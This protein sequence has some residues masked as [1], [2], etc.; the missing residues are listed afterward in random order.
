MTR[1]AGTR[2]GAVPEGPVGRQVQGVASDRGAVPRGAHRMALAGGFECPAC[3]GMRHCVVKQEGRDHYQC[4]AC[5]RQTSL[6]AGTIFASA[7]LELK[8]WL[9]AMFV[10]TQTKQ[11][12]SRLELSR[13]L[14]VTC[15]TAWKIH[16][17]L[18]R[19]MLEREAKKPLR[20]RVEAAD[21][22]LGG[23]RG[24]GKVIPKGQSFCNLVSVRCLR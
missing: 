6:T 9:R 14:G 24:G 12:I 3:G 4:N 22:W 16:Q 19:V 1:N 11:G 5:R 10:I 8:V 18:A 7:R 13:R 20:E 15:D 17:K 23:E 2:F 21:A